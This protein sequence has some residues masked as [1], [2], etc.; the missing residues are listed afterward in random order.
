MYV[1]VRGHSPLRVS[2][3]IYFRRPDMAAKVVESQYHRA[4][5]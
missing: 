1:T 2:R 4:V 3:S 5:E